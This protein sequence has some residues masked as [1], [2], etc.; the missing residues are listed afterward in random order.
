MSAGIRNKP[1]SSW[2]IAGTSFASLSRSPGISDRHCCGHGAHVEVAVP[3]F[4]R[5]AVVAELAA[6]IE[7]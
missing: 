7:N 5:E 6:A 1:V 4:L 2:S 3:L